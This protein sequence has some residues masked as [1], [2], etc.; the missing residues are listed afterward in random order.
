MATSWA[1][2]H[3]D[4]EGEVDYGTDDDCAMDNYMIVQ[5]AGAALAEQKEKQK[6]A[7]P[8]ETEQRKPPAEV[9]HKD[10]VKEERVKRSA[11]ADHPDEHQK[12][13]VGT[14]NW[15]DVRPRGKAMYA[16]D[17]FT[18]PIMVGLCMEMTLEHT[19]QVTKPSQPWKVATEE[20][21]MQE[22]PQGYCAGGS[23]LAH[24]WITTETFH[25]LA[26]IGRCTRVKNWKL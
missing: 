10:D 9:V 3:R 23:I 25:G 2:A 19:D 1:D 11:L 8:V 22:P 14:Y 5:S 21:P 16:K 18:Q 6:C 20:L 26:V 15:G 12:W 17:I 13:T 4:A 24:T 7:A